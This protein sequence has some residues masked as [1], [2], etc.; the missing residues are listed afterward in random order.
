MPRRIGDN[1]LEPATGASRGTT[2]KSLDIHCGRMYATASGRKRKVLQIT[3]PGG[4]TVARRAVIFHEGSTPVDRARGPGARGPMPPMRQ[5]LPLR[6][7]AAEAIVD[8]TP[9]PE[10]VRLA[11]TTKPAKTK[12]ARLANS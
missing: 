5:V 1:I 6:D 7:F 11:K 4:G 12:I 2:M 3:G 9:A 8:V 10:A